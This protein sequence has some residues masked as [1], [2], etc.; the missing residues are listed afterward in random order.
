[1]VTHWEAYNLNTKANSIFQ[2]HRNNKN[3]MSQNVPLRNR[4]NT[5]EWPFK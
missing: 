4:R 5:V 3:K 2:I 1:M